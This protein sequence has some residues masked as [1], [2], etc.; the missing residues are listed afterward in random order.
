MLI[1]ASRSLLLVVDVQERLAAAMEGRDAMVA[2]TG[3]LM[4]AAAEL[5]IPAIVSEQYPQG[6]GHTVGELTEA[7]A[8][9]AIHPKLEFSVLR[10][11]AIADRLSGETRDQIIVA[12]IEAHVCVL[13]SAFDLKAAGRSVFVVADA[14]ASRRMES[15][16]TALQRMA[17]DGIRVVTTEMVVFEW[18]GAASAPAFK[19][20]SKLIR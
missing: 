2:N 1:E 19:T 16:A 11:P 20:L 3:I 12:G 10:N 17:A 15:K 7:A 13:Q 6:L 5:A 14:V 9:A 8:R 4:A 18:L